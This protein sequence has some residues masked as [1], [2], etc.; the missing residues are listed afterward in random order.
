MTG[1]AALC[2]TL[3]LGKTVNVKNCFEWVGLTNCAREIGIIEKEYGF[4]FKRT[5]RK[6]R[7][8]FDQACEWMDYKLVIHEESKV[9]VAKMIEYVLNQMGEAR[10]DEQARDINQI[11]KVQQFCRVIISV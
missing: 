11:L 4:R 3:L 7:S 10:T 9:G 6:G 2:K 5:P 8:R 1:K